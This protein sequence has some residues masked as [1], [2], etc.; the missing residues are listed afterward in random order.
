MS[1]ILKLVELARDKKTLNNIEDNN[2]SK[3][4]DFNDHFAY[5][6]D[7]VRQ[8]NKWNGKITEKMLED[9]NK[10]VDKRQFSQQVIKKSHWN[11]DYSEYWNK[12]Y[13]DSKTY[14][15]LGQEIF[16]KIK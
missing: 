6:N 5:D 11:P 4:Y 3:D 16:N 8:K 2:K 12:E 15:I 14:I 10:S 9:N 7:K 1:N 13:K